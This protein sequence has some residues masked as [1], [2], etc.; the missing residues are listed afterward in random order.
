MFFESLIT[1][2]SPA[3]RQFIQDIYETHGKLMRYLIYQIVRDEQTAEDLLQDAMLRLID[4]LDTLRGLT[5]RQRKAYACRAARNIALNEV[6]PKRRKKYFSGEIESIEDAETGSPLEALQKLED[7]A[8]LNSVLAELPSREREL[9]VDR[10]LLDM[11]TEE[12]SRKA[13]CSRES[14]N[15]RLYDARKNALRLIRKRGEPHE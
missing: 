4:H 8:L 2:E 13:G 11:G 6:D 7:A 12:L 10:Y 14:V 9:L 15:K 5:E 1:L 3:D